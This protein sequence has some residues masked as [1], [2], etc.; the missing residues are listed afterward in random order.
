MRSRNIS[1]M[2]Q[3]VGA[4][5]MNNNMMPDFSKPYYV[6]EAGYKSNRIPIERVSTESSAYSHSDTPIPLPNLKFDPNFQPDAPMTQFNQQPNDPFNPQRN[7][8]K[9]NVGATPITFVIDQFKQQASSQYS[10]I[11]GGGSLMNRFGSLS[12]DLQDTTT[13]FQR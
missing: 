10:D 1:D 12:L 5:Q 4:N 7:P 13:A 8:S 11:Q 2:N 3:S 6:D 9:E